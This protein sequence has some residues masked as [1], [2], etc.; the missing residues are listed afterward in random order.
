MMK[1]VVKLQ[2]Q[3]KQV[4]IGIIFISQLAVYAAC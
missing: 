1:C 4:N 3:W 2:M